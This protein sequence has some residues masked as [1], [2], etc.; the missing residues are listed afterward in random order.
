LHG[1]HRGHSAFCSD[2]CRQR[3]KSNCPLCPSQRQP[4][5]KGSDPWLQFVSIPW[6]LLSAA[7]KGREKWAARLSAR[8]DSSVP[9]SKLNRSLNQLKLID[10]PSSCSSSS[11]LSF[12]FS[13]WAPKALSKASPF[14]GIASNST[15]ASTGPNPPKKYSFLQ[16]AEAPSTN[17]AHRD[18]RSSLW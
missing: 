16:P 3:G 9:V 13:S 15:S 11:S 18:W 2:L 17:A 6:F 12:S 7:H 8:Q 1:P 10:G 4:V 5:A 14:F